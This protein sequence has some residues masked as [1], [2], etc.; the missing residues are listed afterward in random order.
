MMSGPALAD[1][2]AE[3]REVAASIT[4]HVAH[5]EASRR[6]PDEVYRILADS[7]C[8]GR[9]LPAQFGGSGAGLTAFAAQQEALASV[10]PTAA[11][12]ATWANLS[13]RLI[14]RF[15]TAEQRGHLIPG[16]VRGDGLG[17]VGWTEPHGGS[18]AAALRTVGR[19]VPGGWMIDGAKRLIDNAA[20]ATFFIVGC[21]VVDN[22]DGDRDGHRSLAMLLVRP[23]DPGFIYRGRYETMGLRAVGV[24][25]FELQNCFVP[26]DRL[27][28]TVG[29]GFHQMMHMVEFG[30]TGVAAICLGMGEAALRACREFLPGRQAF[31]RSLATNDAIIARLADLRTRL[32]AARLLT[33]RAASMVDRGVPCGRESAMAKLFSS[34]LAVELTSTALHLHGGIGYTTETPL[35]MLLRDSH[36]FTIGE[37][38]SEIMRLIIGRAEFDQD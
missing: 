5:G 23:N 29:R 16:L 7:G 12:A 3:M 17:A 15:G 25:W 31:G 38:T 13:G 33:E 4:E 32:D 26:E 1:L 27:L 36:A 9:T 8:F 10:W 21:R 37:G 35:E 28:G 14:D 34:E 20:A 24:G 22:A 30:R 11:V 2:R 6:I 19:R 18:D